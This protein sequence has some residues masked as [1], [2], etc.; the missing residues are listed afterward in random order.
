[1]AEGISI[2]ESTSNFSKFKPLSRIGQKI[3]LSEFKYENENKKFIEFRLKTLK[4]NDNKTNFVRN[5]LTSYK[6]E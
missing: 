1:M 6:S 2:K 5:K 3:T 4:S